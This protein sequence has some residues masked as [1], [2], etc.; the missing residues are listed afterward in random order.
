MAANVTAE[1]VRAVL[2][3]LGEDALLSLPIAWNNNGVGYFEYTE[4]SARLILADDEWVEEITTY[5]NK[6]YVPNEG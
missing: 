5:I 4:L 3:A 6:A 2:T 1:Q